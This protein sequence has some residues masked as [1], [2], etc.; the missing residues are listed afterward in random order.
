MFGK[1]SLLIISL[2]FGNITFAQNAHLISIN[3]GL[4]NHNLSSTTKDAVNNSGM[5]I[6]DNVGYSFLLNDNWALHTG[7]GLKTFQSS[8]VLTKNYSQPAIDADGETYE[9]VIEFLA[10]TEARKATMLMFPVAV[11]YYKP[12]Y[13][14]MD[15]YASLGVEVCVPQQASYEV[16]S[17]QIESAGDYS[18]YNAELR[19]LPQ[20][21][22]SKDLSNYSGDIKLRNSYSLLM[23]FGGIFKLTDELGLGIVS[24][25][26]YGLND[27][28]IPV[29]HS[30]YTITGVYNGMITS[31]QSTELNLMSYGVKMALTWKIPIK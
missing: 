13:T 29:N 19:D 9:H 12:V 30:L 24:Y 22:F 5:G 14:I 17:G 10:L 6:F 1:K 8:S 31:T 4:G 16:V 3:F 7:F 18:Q 21:G 15:M 20:H 2:A 23:Q 28:L 11:E 26:T 25:F 27:V